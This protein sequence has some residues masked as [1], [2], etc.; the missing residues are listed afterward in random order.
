[1]LFWPGRVPLGP[2]IELS[3]MP[4][5]CHRAVFVSVGDQAAQPVAA[6]ARTDFNPR[7]TDALRTPSLQRGHRDV[8]ESG[9]FLAGHKA[10]TV[11]GTKARI[12]YPARC[13]LW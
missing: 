6:P 3:R 13:R 1:M 5:G 11:V 9:R 4:S 8:E 10:I 12:G 2:V 7:R